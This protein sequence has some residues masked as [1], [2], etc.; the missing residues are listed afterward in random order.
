MLYGFDAS[1]P[2]ATMPR[3]TRIVFGYIGGDTPHVWTPDEWKRYGKR[4]KVPIFVPKIA[5][6]QTSDAWLDCQ[7]LLIDLFKLRVPKGNPVVFDME[8]KSDNAYLNQC[9]KILSWYG[10]RLWVY[11]SESTVFDNPV[12][13]GYFV[14]AWRGTKPFIAK[15]NGVVATQWKSLKEYD[16]D[17]VRFW[18]GW[19]ILRPW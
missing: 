18:P 17:A 15:G 8:G 19:F 3:D 6:G 2:P 16:L 1:I 5:V 11:G 9:H 4:R 12:C 10:Y 14:A 7:G 13:D